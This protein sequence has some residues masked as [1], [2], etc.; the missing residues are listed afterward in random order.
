MKEKK[1]FWLWSTPHISQKKIVRIFK[2]E[3]SPSFYSFAAKM[4]SHVK[5]PKEAFKY[6]SKETFCRNWPAIKTEIKKDAWFAQMTD[7]W[8]IVYEDA[9][10]EL[11]DRGIKIQ[12]FSS[13]GITPDRLKLAK[14]I[15]S[16][17]LKAGYSQKWI[18]QLLDVKQPFISKLEAGKVNVSFDMLHKI[19]GTCLKGVRIRF[20]S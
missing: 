16:M 6:M 17:R 20:V 18:A 10:K 7:H 5:D 8:Q 4:F 2:D 13:V 15:R 9:I 11:K 3:E 12:K 14:D 19:A 1:P